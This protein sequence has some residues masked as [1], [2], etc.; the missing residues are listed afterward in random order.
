ME[1]D[2]LIPYPETHLTFMLQTKTFR[3]IQP[4][5][6]QSQVLEIKKTKDMPR[7]R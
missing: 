3:A 2:I 7:L 1:Y 4:E 5:S 6:E